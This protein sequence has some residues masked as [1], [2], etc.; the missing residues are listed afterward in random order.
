MSLR[1]VLAALLAAAAGQ[2][3]RA[4]TQQAPQQAHRVIFQGFKG[5]P[6]MSPRAVFEPAGG[7]SR[8]AGVTHTGVQ[9]PSKPLSRHAE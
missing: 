2:L 7:S 3:G 1:A 6:G 8:A 4:A 5:G 9:P